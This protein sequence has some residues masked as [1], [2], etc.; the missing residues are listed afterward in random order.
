[1]TNY[2][3]KVLPPQYSH[4]NN[5][6]CLLAATVFCALPLCSTEAAAENILKYDGTTNNHGDAKIWASKNEYDGIDIR[7]T[8]VDSGY[9]RETTEALVVNGKTLNVKGKGKFVRIVNTAQNERIDNN[10]G[11]YA[12]GGSTVNFTDVDSIYI[13]AIAGKEGGNDSTVI[14]A[15]DPLLEDITGHTNTINIS[16]TV[17]QLIGSIDVIHSFGSVLNPNARHTVNAALSGSDSFWYG[18]AIG[19]S[20]ER[21]AVNLSLADGATWIFNAGRSLLNA[22]GI[23]SNLKLDKGVV[24]FADAEVW[25]TYRKTVIKGT[26]YVLA[27]FRDHNERYSQVEIRNLTGPGGIFKIDLDWQS[28]NGERQYTEK[29]D[30][31]TI[32]TAEDGSHQIVEFDMGKAHL[33]EMKNGDKLFFASVESGNTTFSTNADGEVNRADELYRFALHTQSE[34]DETD[35]LTYWFLTKSIGS[36][37]ENVDFLNNA[38]LAS[39]SLAS[40]LD[41][42]HERQ[43][44][45]RHEERG[46]NGL[47]ARYR[48]SD[49][50]RKHAFDM[51]KNMIQVGYNKEVSTADSHKIVSLAFDYTRA[52]TDLFGVSGQDDLIQFSSLTLNTFFDFFH[53]AAYFVHFTHRTSLN[54]YTVFFAVHLF[55]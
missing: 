32:G 1:M 4:V 51:D 36:A 40:D 49:I 46:T 29:S 37:N 21:T 11:I 52:D 55:R 7:I 25:E 38:V 30:F 35:Q 50:G 24:L 2:L 5:V 20:D 43:G 23:I 31:I 48:Y 33:D 39:F 17:I 16:G 41:R 6:Y 3:Y 45:A 47:W 44:E 18:S 53:F 42:F 22:G 27:N 15:K 34:E 19:E 10:G 54:L 28:N 13:A 14:S 9:Y 12:K 26:D 8:G